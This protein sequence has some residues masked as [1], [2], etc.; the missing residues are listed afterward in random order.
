[1]GIW[2]LPISSRMVK[3]IVVQPLSLYLKIVFTKAK[4]TIT[5]Q[6]IIRIKWVLLY[7]IWHNIHAA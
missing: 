6:I 7:D 3:Y 5:L 4:N 2:R 1:M